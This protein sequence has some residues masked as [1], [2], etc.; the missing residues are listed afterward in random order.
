MMNEEEE[1][2]QQ[3]AAREV[4]EEGRA[5]GGP[6]CNAYFRINAWLNPDGS[7]G[8]DFKYFYEKVPPEA[9]AATLSGLLDTGRIAT[10]KVADEVER[11]LLINRNEFIK[12]TCEL[13][14]GLGQDDAGAGAQFSTG[15]VKPIRNNPKRF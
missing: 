12:R 14:K 13:A 8:A 6:D 9:I 4:R 7:V 2:P 15:P 1:T 3:R 5:R 10:E 11:T